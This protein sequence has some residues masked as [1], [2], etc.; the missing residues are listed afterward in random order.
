MRYLL[1]TNICIA[2]LRGLF[3]YEEILEK[4]AEEDCYISELTRYELKAGESLARQKHIGFKNQGL[5]KLLALFNIIPIAKA[6]DFAAD[7][8]ARLQLAGTPVDDDFDML[9]GSTSVVYGMTM[10]TENVRHFKEIN[11]I[12][13]ENWI[14]RK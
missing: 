5:E 3:N 8:K 11:G 9:I 7:E 12:R 2:I 14:K 1:D 13:I 6:I 4:I 10:A